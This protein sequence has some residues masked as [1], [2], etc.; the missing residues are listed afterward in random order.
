MR[1]IILIISAIIVL[2]AFFACKDEQTPPPV[3]EKPVVVVPPEEPKEPPVEP[4]DPPVEPIV[5]IDPPVV[6]QLPP[7]DG[8]DDVIPLTVFPV[9]E[10]CGW[11]Y[12]FITDQ[13]IHDMHLV[14]NSQEEMVQKCFVCEGRDI[15]E[16]DFNTHTMLVFIVDYAYKVTHQLQ[17]EDEYRYNWNIDIDIRGGGRRVDLTVLASKLP[18]GAQVKVNVNYK[19]V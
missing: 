3:V 17:R 4:V 5:P 9:P 18:Q 14:I 10:G 2:A 1:K 12:V 8:E 16:V 6:E 13:F 7:V 19:P 11:G 15:P